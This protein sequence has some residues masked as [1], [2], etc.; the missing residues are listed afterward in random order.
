MIEAVRLW[1]EP[2]ADIEHHVARCARVGLAGADQRVVDPGS[3]HAEREAQ[4]R[5]GE[6]L[7]AVELAAMSDEDGMRLFGHGR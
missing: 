2:A 1:L 3:R 6:H 4:H 5:I 7:V